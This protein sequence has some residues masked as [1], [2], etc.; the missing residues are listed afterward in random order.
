MNE[1][2]KPDQLQ[3][4]FNNQTYDQFRELKTLIDSKI[5]PTILCKNHSKIPNYNSIIYANKAFY[6]SFMLSEN[7]VIGQNY[8]FLFSQLDLDNFSQDQI[9]YGRLLKAVRDHQD[10]SVV[11]S[12]FNWHFKNQNNKL[13]I[14]FSA[15]KNNKKDISNYAI[16]SFLKIENS[17]NKDDSNF[18]KNNSNI[19]L[20]RV[21]ERT[22][23]SERLLREIANLIISDVKINSLAQTIAKILCEHLKCD[24]CIIHDFKKGKTDFVIEYCSDFS[25]KMLP[26]ENDEIS[27]NNIENVK[28]YINFQNNFYKKFGSNK[29]NSSISIVP[30]VLNDHNFEEIKNICSQYA[31]A[32]QIAI[33]TN[34]G[35]LVNGGIYLHQSEK[36]VWNQDEID[37]IE[38]VAEQFSIALDRSSS[39]QKVMIANHSLMEKTMLLKASLKQE[40][41][42][43]KMQNEFVALV[44]HEFKTPLQIIDGNR[45]LITRK[46]KNINCQDESVFNYLNKIKTGILRMNGLINST[47]HLA[48]MENGSK[49]I[50]VDIQP[51]NLQQLLQEIIDKNSNLA[52]QKNIEILH[53]ITDLPENYFSDIKLLDHIFTNLISN[54]IKYSNINSEV[55]IIGKTMDDCIAIR[56][57][58]YGIGIP[59]KDLQNVGKKFYRATNSLSVAGTGIGIYLTKHFIDLLSGKLIIDSKENFGT[60]VTI[61]LKK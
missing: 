49:A 50:N 6:D 47:L 41:E 39:I 52:L 29:K 1:Q 19:A 43:R 24:R 10:C 59:Q 37:L 25:A 48:K 32:S 22:L 51:L 2:I 61:I 12:N 42:M 18:V 14:H 46:L 5:E 23:R 55:K 34:F 56:I 45:E 58:D 30:D 8:D 31:I 44:S 27:L 17:E 7:E 20:L 28:K 40:K 21:L 11:L 15:L 13:H 35:G 38:I 36:R 26:K 60:N 53:K 3:D 16:F 4:F 33:T 9:E 54:A 57:I